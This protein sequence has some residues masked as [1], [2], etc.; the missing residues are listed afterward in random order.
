MLP[1]LPIDVT[2]VP[3]AS[4]VPPDARTVRGDVIA[5]VEVRDDES[6][7]LASRALFQTCRRPYDGIGDR[8][9]IRAISLRLTSVMC[10]LGL[11]PNQVTTVNILIGLVACG[12]AGPFGGSRQAFALAGALMFL[13]IV[14]DSCDG[15]LARIR[16][17]SS[18]FGMWLDNTSDDVIDNLFIAM[19]GVGLGGIWLPI[20]VAAAC[21]R[22]ACCLMIHI[23]VARLGKPG[24]IMV[25][26]WWFDEADEALAERFDTKM[27]VLGLL[28]AV[29][30]RDLYV[31]LWSAFCVAGLP[32]VALGLGVAIS[33]I[34][35]SL[36]LVHLAV[37]RR[38]KA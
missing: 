38:A 27:S 28:R 37:V 9:V 26:R 18:R 36:M 24:D 32:V 12:F 34:Y 22:G 16:H 20:G 23:A 3:L 6:R 4:P 10:R 21:A 13:Q 1:P 8:Y 19:L 14:L 15:E 33:A 31:L 11:T 2:I 35:F 30:R 29:G 7:R 5:N 17:L 25:F